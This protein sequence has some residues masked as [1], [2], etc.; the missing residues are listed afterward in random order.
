MYIIT[1][2]AFFCI[3][4]CNKDA[5]ACKISAICLYY[6]KFLIAFMSLSFNR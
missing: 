6:G 4:P 5:T 3:L 2:V 1:D